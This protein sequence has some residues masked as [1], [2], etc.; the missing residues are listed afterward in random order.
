[1]I[2]ELGEARPNTSNFRKAFAALFDSGA[3]VP[4]GRRAVSGHPGRPGHLDR[5]QG[6]LAGT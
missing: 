3:L 6:P 1:M 4:V 2:S 5:F